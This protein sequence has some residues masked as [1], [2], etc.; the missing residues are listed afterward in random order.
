VGVLIENGIGC[1][2][3]FNI[4]SVEILY[5]GISGDAEIIFVEDWLLAE[6]EEV[7]VGLYFEGILIV[8]IVGI[9]EIAGW[10]VS[11]TES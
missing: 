11:F 2:W 8:E 1:W 6:V 4:L 7:F 10:S 5:A 9:V 3:W